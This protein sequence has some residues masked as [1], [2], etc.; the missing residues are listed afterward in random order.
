[1]GEPVEAGLLADAGKKPSDADVREV[2]GR[3]FTHWRTLV[4]GVA[5]I[6]PNAAGAW[7]FYKSSGWTFVIR[8]KKRNLL[9]LRP[10]KGKIL[11]S[12]ALGEAAYKAALAS[13]LPEDLRAELRAAPK[14]PEGRPARVGVRTQ[15]EVKTVLK[16]IELK[17]AR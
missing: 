14:Y 10:V 2:L 11:T 12:M 3:A 4:D 1:M 17:A 8:D 7:R 13:E 16:L 5:G 9:Y 6:E 15:A